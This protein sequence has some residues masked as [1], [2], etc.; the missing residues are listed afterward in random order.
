MAVW[1]GLN[2]PVQS[3]M[4]EATM[5]TP[6]HWRTACMCDFNARMV[7]VAL[8]LASASARSGMEAPIAYARVMKITVGPTL[9][10]VATVVIVERTGPAQGTNTN[11]TNT[12]R[13][14][15]FDRV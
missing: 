12:P 15:P 10:A 11:P 9:W 6:D 13:H 4:P 8:L 1:S 3:A 2:R 14:T 7:P 5:S